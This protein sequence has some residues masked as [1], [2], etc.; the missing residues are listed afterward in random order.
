MS[1]VLDLRTQ[2]VGRVFD[3]QRW[4]LHD[5]PG[6]RT[7]VFLKGCSLQCMWCANPE[8]WAGEPEMAY[9]EDECIFSGACANACPY[10]AITMTPTGP[11]TDWT[12]CKGRC[13]KEAESPYPCTNVCHAQARRTL[14]RHMSVEQVLAT[15]E[16]DRGIYRDSGGGLSVSGGEPFYQAAFLRALLRGAKERWINTVVE[17][18]GFASWTAYEKALE[19][20]DFMFLDIKEMDPQKH[21][22]FTGQRNEVILHNARKIAEFMHAKGAPLVIRT[23]VVPGHTATERNVQAIAAFAR[24]LPGVDTHELM[25][26]HRLGRG[27]FARIGREYELPDLAPPTKEQ[28]EPLLAIVA[29]AGLNPKWGPSVDESGLRHR[30]QSGR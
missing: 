16:R 21:H 28:M 20:V 7:T 19:Y 15:V 18:C 12:I 24:S 8:S 27:K 5:G 13:Y 1:N 17:S 3:I 25:P 23:P 10:G 9:F 29:D 4:S 2:A 6:I 26:Y 11:V 22:D 14:G 30:N